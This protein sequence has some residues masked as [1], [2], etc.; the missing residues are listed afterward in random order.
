MDRERESALVAKSREG[1]ERAFEELVR[2]SIDGLYRVAYRFTNSA[3]DA[4]DL[5]QEAF[6][7]GHRSLHRFRG[8][9]RFRT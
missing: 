3:A 4:E 8:E 6:F 7:K 5:V 2:D 9:S 1:D